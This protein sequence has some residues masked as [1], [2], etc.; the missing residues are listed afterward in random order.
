[1]A[2]VTALAPIIGYDQAAKI[3]KE[4][5]QTGKTVRELCSEQKVM[6]EADLE[7]ALNPIA[8]TE[9]GG[10]GSAGG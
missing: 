9:P 3:A 2:M 6:P 8:M 4:S 10:E 1:M 7:K 5:A